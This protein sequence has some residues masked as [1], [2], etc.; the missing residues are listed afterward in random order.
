MAVMATVLMMSSTRQPRLR[1]LTGLLSPCSTGPG[2]YDIASKPALS[3]THASPTT[4]RSAF[5][6]AA[7]VPASSSGSSA[8]RC[9]GMMSS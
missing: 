7:T 8:S 2:V 3:S 6:P 1:S 4:A 9:A 5:P